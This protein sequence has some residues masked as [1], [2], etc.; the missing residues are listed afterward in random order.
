MVTNSNRFVGKSSLINSLLDVQRLAKAVGY[1]L[2][3]SMEP[4][5]SN[6]V[7]MG[8]LAHQLQQ[9]IGKNA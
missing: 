3:I 2:V 9:N 5:N 4:F 7:R 1:D 6:R 8:R